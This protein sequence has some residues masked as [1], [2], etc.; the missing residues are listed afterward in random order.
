MCETAGYCETMYARFMTNFHYG[1]AVVYA[2][3][4]EGDAGTALVERGRGLDLMV[5][6]SKGHGALGRVAR[7]T[8]SHHLMCNSSTPVLAASPE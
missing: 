4:F 3:S 1:V 2:V 5:V 8:V 7:G 6:G